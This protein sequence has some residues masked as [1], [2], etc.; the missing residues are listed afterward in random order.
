MSEINQVPYVLKNTQSKLLSPGQTDATLLDH[1]ATCWAGLAKRTQHC[2]TWLPNARNMFR[3]TMLHDVAPTWLEDLWDQG[4]TVAKKLN[5]SHRYLLVSSMQHKLCTRGTPLSYTA[6]AT[7]TD[8]RKWRQMRIYAVSPMVGPSVVLF[9]LCVFCGCL[10][11]YVSNFM[12]VSVLF[13]PSIRVTHLWAS[14]RW[15]RT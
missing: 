10:D 7:I 6:M 13:M 9:R 3:A 2:T 12:Y 15:Q 8:Q 11:F 4:T 1:V 5:A 14:K